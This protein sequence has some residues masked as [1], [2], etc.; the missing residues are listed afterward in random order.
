MEKIKDKIITFTFILFVGILMAVV[1]NYIG[2]NPSKNDCIIGQDSTD[3]LD[4]GGSDH[5]LWNN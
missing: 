3:C 4:G 1:F 5:P 2:N